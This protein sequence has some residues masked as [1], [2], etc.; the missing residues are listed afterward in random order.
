MLWIASAP[1]LGSREVQEHLGFN[2]IELSRE[3]HGSEPTY[4][5][6]VRRYGREG[7][8]WKELSRMDCRPGA[9]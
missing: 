8:S 1:S 7:G 4:L 9:V 6:T 2:D 3:P 5:L